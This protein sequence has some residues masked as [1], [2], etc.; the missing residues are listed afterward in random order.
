MPQAKKTTRVSG[1]QLAVS[2]HARFLNLESNSNNSHNNPNRIALA[3]LRRTLVGKTSLEHRM[4]MLDIFIDA[5]VR[6]GHLDDEGRD[7]FVAYAS[8][9]VRGEKIE[10]PDIVK[11]HCLMY[12]C[13]LPCSQGSCT[14]RG[15]GRFVKEIN[16][17]RHYFCSATCFMAVSSPAAVHTT[18]KGLSPA[19]AP[20]VRLPRSPNDP[21]MDVCD[22]VP[23]PP[24][25]AV[26]VTEEAIH[27]D[28][29]SEAAPTDGSSPS[30]IG[31]ALRMP[32]QD[33]HD[34]T[35]EQSKAVLETQRLLAEVKAATADALS[36]IAKREHAVLAQIAATTQTALK[37]IEE[38]RERT[39]RPT[40]NEESGR[41]RRVRDPQRPLV[42]PRAASGKP[43]PRKRGDPEVDRNGFVKGSW[44]P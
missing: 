10:T 8:A 41:V 20:I 7:A 13:Q 17:E 4:K 3:K 39:T 21:T 25:T 30:E 1:G 19:L 44:N 2:D 14:K 26:V 23:E 43:S 9:V 37:A 24:D 29:T 31:K 12:L 5:F 18:S 28:T 33:A 40:L 35:S 11:K 36:S 32:Q 15:T 38:A 6:N 34:P 22:P 27:P 16:G 42:S